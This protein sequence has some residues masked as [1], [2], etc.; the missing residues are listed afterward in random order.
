MRKQ[1]G[2]RIINTISRNAETNAPT[3]SAYSAAKAAIW[4][5][6]RV[7]ANEVADSNILINMLIDII[8][9]EIVVSDLII[10][11]NAIK[12]EAN[13]PRPLNIATIWGMEV[14]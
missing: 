2:G 13:P 11:E 4:S 3:T 5:A 9:K 7:T 14:I 1:G 8:F 10:S 12:D 6:T